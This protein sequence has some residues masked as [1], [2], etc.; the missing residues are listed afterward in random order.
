MH[1]N[2]NSSPVNTDRCNDPLDPCGDCSHC[3][4]YEAFLAELPPPPSRKLHRPVFEDGI[5]WR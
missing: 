5:G 4:E 1:T 2:F 3:K